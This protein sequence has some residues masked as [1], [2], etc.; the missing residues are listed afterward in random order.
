L[1][2]VDHAHRRYLATLK[3]LAV[4]RRLAVPTL[5]VNIAR[6]QVVTSPGP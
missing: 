1:K 4:V 2:R 5:Q 6:Q 3:V